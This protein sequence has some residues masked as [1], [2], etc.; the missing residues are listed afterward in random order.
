MTI[1]SEIQLLLVEDDIMYSTK[2]ENM[3]EE[4][5]IENIRCV[6]SYESALWEIENNCPQL[7]LSDIFL[8]G[9]KTGIDLFDVASEKNIPFIFMTQYEKEHLCKDKMNGVSIPYLIKPIHKLT[10]N[11]LINVVLDINHNQQVQ[12]LSL[13]YI[14]VRTGKNIKVKLEYDEILWIKT[15][16]NYIFLHTHKN[17]YVLK[18]SLTN[19][20][21][22][23]DGRFIRVHHSYAINMN[24]FQT[25]TSDYVKISNNQIPISRTFKIDLLQRLKE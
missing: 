2:I 19:I 3:I 11:S 6:E 14:Y 25:M 1:Y 4:I 20:L 10:L 17:K 21:S 16:A 15:E 13:K 22:E 5:G 8:R 23:L 12:N 7:I 24:H 9:K 18:K